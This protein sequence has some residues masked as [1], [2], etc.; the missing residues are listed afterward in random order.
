M[1]FQ[2]YYC[3][4]YTCYKI[5]DSHLPKLFAEV[6]HVSPFTIFM[7]KKKK[8]EAQTEKKPGFLCP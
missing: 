6:F 8:K 5:S 2:L 1:T 4:S 7:L 3:Y